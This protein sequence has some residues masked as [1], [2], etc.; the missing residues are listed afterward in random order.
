MSGDTQLWCCQICGRLVQQSISC[1]VCQAINYCSQSHRQRHWRN[2]HS[3]ECT[4]MKQ[5]MMG[6][7]VRRQGIL[8]YCLDSWPDQLLCRTLVTFHSILHSKQSSRYILRCRLRVSPQLT[9]VSLLRWKQQSQHIVSFCHGGVCTKRASGR[10]TVPVI[11]AVMAQQTLMS[12]L[13]FLTHKCRLVLAT[14]YCALSAS[15]SD[16]WLMCA[17]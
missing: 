16:T 12:P 2:C 8:P 1:P 6:R 7:H 15:P 5:Q 11:K 10:L 9:H 17:G 13:P 3:D 14:S 4:R